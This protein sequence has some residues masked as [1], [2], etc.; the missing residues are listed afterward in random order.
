MGPIGSLE[1]EPAARAGRDAAFASPSAAMGDG[2]PCRA[3][4][5]RRRGRDKL[6][7]RPAVNSDRQ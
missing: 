3:T 6:A 1:Q 5:V 2:W 7:A 4:E